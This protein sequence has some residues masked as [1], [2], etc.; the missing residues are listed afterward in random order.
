MADRILNRKVKIF[1]IITRLDMGGSAQ[2][3]LDTCL[4]L[5]LC[6]YSVSLVYGLA[7][8]SKM[9]EAER[10]RVERKI[11]RGR[12]TGV[13]FM[14]FPD[15]VRRINPIKDLKALHSLI[16]LIKQRKP[17]IV[18]T[19]S[20][21][22]GVLG[23]LAAKLAGVPKIVHTPHGHVFYGHFHPVSARI[24]IW[25]ERLFSIFTDRM[26]ALTEGEKNDYINLSVCHPRRLMQVHSGV[27]LKQFS[28]LT[29]DFQK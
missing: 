6:K 7:H 17:D 22:A 12:E 26:I 29:I 14:P 3:T 2:N 16:K 28:T 20:S 19:H 15:L 23:R 4:N 21:K 9:T 1:H 10:T 24:F 11:H 13:T 8:E 25:I 18:H 5:D 27:D